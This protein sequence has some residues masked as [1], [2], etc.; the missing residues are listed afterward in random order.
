MCLVSYLPLSD[1]FIISSNR[2]ETPL[3]SDTKLTKESIND[4][5]ILFPKDQ[6]GGSW[7]IV[8]KDGRAICVLNG[9]FKKHKR[10]HN[11][12]M[13]RGLMMKHYFEYNSTTSFL[14][15]FD[16]SDI[17]AFTCLLYTSDAADD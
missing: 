10:K 8:S 14:Q 13:S 6:K 3:R 1:G 17:E 16:F 9:A 5:T 15:D 2:D 11:Y 4:T 7:I 12:R